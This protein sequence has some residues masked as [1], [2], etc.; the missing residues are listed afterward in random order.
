MSDPTTPVGES[1][2][3]RTGVRVWQVLVLGVGVLLFTGALAFFLS[4]TGDEDDAGATRQ[5]A[6]AALT[7]TRSDVEDLE[8]DISL[9]RNGI[10]ERVAAQDTIMPLARN[11]ADVANRLGDSA[12]HI[13]ELGAAGSVGTAEFSAV[14]AEGNQLVTEY[15]EILDTLRGIGPPS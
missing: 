9:D 14:L 5:R 13:Q 2:P 3:S 10:Q 7:K 4:A 6:Q 11:V 15:N 12:V 8:T 1:S